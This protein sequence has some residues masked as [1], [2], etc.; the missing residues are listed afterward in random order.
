MLVAAVGLVNIDAFRDMAQIRRTEL[1]WAI[2]AFLGVI[3]L[4]VLEGILVAVLISIL[5]LL[6]QAQRPPVYAL[7]HK[8]GTEEF[9]SLGDH[10]ND[11]TFSGLL[12]V[13]TEG[14]L[15]FAN[16]SDVI[17]KLWVLIHDVSPAPQVVI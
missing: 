8:P 11:E 3:T 1:I 10:R 15:F 7:G 9:R 16:V 13:R 14:R 6:T 2:V 5:T 12:I 17:D 4:G